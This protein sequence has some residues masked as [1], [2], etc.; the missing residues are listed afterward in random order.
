MT[1]DRGAATRDVWTATWFSAALSAITVVGLLATYAAA[2]SANPSMLL[3][4]LCNI[5]MAFMFAAYPLK[6]AHDRIQTLE[7]RLLKLEAT[8]GEK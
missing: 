3:V 8:H 7:E 6:R 2:G 4:F 1:D 5:P